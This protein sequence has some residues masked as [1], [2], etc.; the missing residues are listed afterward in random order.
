ML[1]TYDMN[2]LE[3]IFGSK[4]RARLLTLLFDSA[5]AEYHLRDIARKTDLA[6]RTIQQDI[7]K[8][9]KVELITSRR[10]GNR[11]YFKANKNHPI[12]ADIRQII[13][14]TTGLIPLLG[15]ALKNSKEIQI[16]FVF[17]SFGR[18]TERAES[19]VDLIVIGSIGLR[20]LMPLVSKVTR[21]VGR[22][23][24]P[25]IFTESEYAERLKAKNHF[26]K[27]VLKTPK[28]FVIGSEDE[29]KAMGR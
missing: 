15:N 10:D 20:K 28:I 9:I 12:T 4:V 7:H 8:L 19:D 5:E 3:L 1:L 27:E 6:I 26:L 21:T 17:G 25:H 29:L 13:Q 16:A 24:N 2:Q 18:E 11:L 22:E 14:K 23:I